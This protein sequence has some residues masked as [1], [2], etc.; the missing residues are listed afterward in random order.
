[1]HDDLLAYGHLGMGSLV[2]NRL[3]SWLIGYGYRPLRAAGFIAGFVSFGALL[4]ALAKRKGL[5]I[6]EHPVEFRPDYIEQPS[7]P[8][9]R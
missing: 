1:M 2:W 8:R 4:L 6:P 7:W 9:A 5:T 3:L